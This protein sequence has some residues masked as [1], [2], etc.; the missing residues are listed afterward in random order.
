MN[1]YEKIAK[2]Y[3]ERVGYTFIFANEYK[4][5]VMNPETKEMWSLNWEEVAKHLEK[6]IEAEKVLTK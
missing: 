1:E 4:V 2:K 6:H 5:G 3:C